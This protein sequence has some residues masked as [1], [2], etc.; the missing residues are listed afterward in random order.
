[1]WN[2][3]MSLLPYAYEVIKWAANTSDTMKICMFSFNILVKNENSSPYTDHP[4]SHIS[5]QFSSVHV[6]WTRI[7]M[8]EAPQMWQMLASCRN[9]SIGIILQSTKRF[10]DY[11]K[12][13]TERWQY[14]MSALETH[15]RMTVFTNQRE[16]YVVRAE[17]ELLLL[18]IC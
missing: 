10:A 9:G 15:E 12:N 6:L 16:T 17:C 4:K 5:P 14:P 18:L 13:E 8:L 7:N 11:E 1:M 2:K 3:I